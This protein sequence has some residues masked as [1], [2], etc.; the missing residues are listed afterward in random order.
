M[1]RAHASVPLPHEAAVCCHMAQVQ[2]SNRSLHSPSAILAK[3]AFMLLILA[4]PSISLAQQPQLKKSRGPYY[5]GDAVQVQIS[6][7]VEDD[8]SNIE[9]VYTGEVED[10]VV[11]APQRGLTQSGS[12]ITFNGRLVQK[13]SLVHT[14]LFRVR[15]EK[16]GEVLVGPFLLTVD[17]QE[18]V[19][20]GT[21]FDFESLEPDEG[22]SLE[23]EFSDDRIYVGEK[24]PLK[25]TWT[26]EGDRFARQL[27]AQELV[28]R[29][30]MFDQFQ[31]DDIQGRSADTMII[32]TA[33]GAFRIVADKQDVRNLEEGRVTMTAVRTLAANSPGRYEEVSGSCRTIRG[34]DW[35]R[36]FFDIV[37]R[38][39]TPAICMTSPFSFEVLPLP[40][41]GQPASFTGAVGKGFAISASANRSVVRVGDPISLDITI[42]GDGNIEELSIPLKSGSGALDEDLFQLPDEIPSGTLTDNSKQFKVPIRVKSESVNQ[43][44]AIAFSWF[45]PEK[46]EYQT[47]FSK[48]I[49]LQV[50]ETQIISAAD[51]VSSAA[52][53]PSQ[54]AT[55]PKQSTSAASSRALD[56]VGANL[57]IENNPVKLLAATNLFASSWTAPALHIVG[58]LFVVA[59]FLVRR[60]RQSDPIQSQRKQLIA[61]LRSEISKSKTQPAKEAASEVASAMRKLLV[62]CPQSM[63]PQVESL[64]ADAENL[65]FSPSNNDSAQASLVERAQQSIDQYSKEGRQ[66]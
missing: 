60:S 2:C 52:Q 20:P 5:V 7:E 65:I 47:A 41:Q 36:D 61:S 12:T 4:G 39:R 55:S 63:R 24:V 48:P 23:F 13:A 66:R 1:K 3:L 50:M 45:D 49:A 58:V 18:R 43:L 64:I 15:A 54:E 44:P 37:P 22:M 14:F 57:A 40:L 62:Q 21:S 42:Q 10:V 8:S 28:V 32:D 11:S 17:G 26:F 51:V 38:K 35:V 46:E 16:P 33:E 59:A 27:A 34:S 29:S 25:I 56:F 31:F 19:I 30:T 53:P 6:I 9:C